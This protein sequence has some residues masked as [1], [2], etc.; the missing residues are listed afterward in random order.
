MF[1]NM[2]ERNMKIIFKFL[3]CFTVFGLLFLE[4]NVCL[5]QQ[6]LVATAKIKVIYTLTPSDV[7]QH[8]IYLETVNPAVSDPGTFGCSFNLIYFAPT[9]SS[10]QRDR[11]IY[12]TLLTAATVGLPFSGYYTKTTT[13]PGGAASNTKVCVLDRI[14]LA[15]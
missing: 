7:Y 12:Q 8:A 2:G 6:A 5:A 3:A 11:S 13:T 15:F 10:T 1:K 14:D 9:G 4:P